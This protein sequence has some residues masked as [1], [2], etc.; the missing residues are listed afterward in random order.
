MANSRQGSSGYRLGVTPTS[1]AMKPDAAP[2]PVGSSSRVHCFSY[3]ETG[4]KFADCKRG[5]KKRLFVDS[6][7][8]QEE[9]V[10]VETNPA[11][12]DIEV[13]KEERLEGD[14]IPL[15]VVWRSCL[16]PRGIEDD[17]LRTNMFQSTCTIGGKI[18]RFIVN[19]GSCEN[20][21]SKETVRKL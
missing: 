13:I 1:T 15:L 17:W 9:P 6:E 2:P 14:C 18:Y 10:D 4:H 5:P 19:S 11:F 12:D 7:D 16:A 21:I 20:V 3:G 8:M